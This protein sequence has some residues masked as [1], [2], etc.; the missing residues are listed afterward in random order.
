MSAAKQSNR[1]PAGLDG[2]GGETDAGDVT[3]WIREVGKQ[4]GQAAEAIWNRYFQRL[5]YFAR[6][7]FAKLPTRVADEEDVALSA[8]NSF[9]RG[10]AKGQFPQLADRR[11]LWRI[12]ITI[13]ARKVYAQM[14]RQGADK[15]GGGKVRGESVFVQRD[16]QDALGIEQVFGREPTPEL[17]CMVA[18]DC[19]RLLDML[20]DETLREVAVLKLEGHTNDEIATRLNCVTRTVERKLDRIREKWSREPGV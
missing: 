10:A 1:E 5:T 14:R 3:R 11:D 6:Q 12:L 4:D 18:E 16:N 9:Y 19:N 2:G 15:R 20:G 17:A 7:K 8:L 13:A